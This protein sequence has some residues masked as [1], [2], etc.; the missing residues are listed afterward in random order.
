MI[1][2]FWGAR[3]RVEAG[4][5]ARREHA[6]WLTAALRSG[7]AFPRI[8]VRRVDHGGYSFLARRAG[9]VERAQRWWRLALERVD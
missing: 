9:G 4:E 7:R 1:W 3:D 6:R 8:P 5:L 2:T